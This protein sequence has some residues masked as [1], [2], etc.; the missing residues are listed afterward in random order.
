MVRY[1]SDVFDV[2]SGSVNEI[3]TPD[4]SLKIH[5]SKIKLSGEH[6]DVGIYFISENSNE[7]TKVPADEIIVN[8]PS[9]LIISIPALDSGSYFLEITTQYSNSASLLKEPRIARFDKSLFVE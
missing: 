1:P 9:E 5:G 2:K 8:N 7:K 3:L 4:K 6:E